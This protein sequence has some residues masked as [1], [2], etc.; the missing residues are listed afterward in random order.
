MIL[1]PIAELP[2]FCVS[3]S[4]RIVKFNIFSLATGEVSLWGCGLE[5]L[6]FFL[7]VFGAQGFGA[8]VG[9]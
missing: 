8:F 4:C 5:G 3:L 9:L 2:L 6:E 1:R 7:R